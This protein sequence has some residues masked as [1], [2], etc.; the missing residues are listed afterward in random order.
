MRI[1]VVV[2]GGMGETLQATPLLRTLRAGFPQ[3]RISLLHPRLATAVAC[4]IPSADELVPERC[5]EGHAGPASLIPLWL[6][7]RRRRLDA[8]FIC[9]GQP[10]LRVAAYLAGVPERVGPSGGLTSVL[11]T[12]GTPA[13]EHENHAATWLRLASSLGLTVQ[14]HAPSFDPGPEAKR[15]ANKLLHGTGLTDGRLLIAIVPGTSLTER[16][17]SPVGAVGWDPQRFAFLAN[18]LAQR[19]GAGIVFLGGPGDRAEIEQVQ[20]D[21]GI[22]VADMSGELD[23][24][25]VAAIVSHCDLLVAADSP[26]LHIAAAV[27]TPAVGLFG[28][29]DGRKRGPYGRDHRII[30]ALPV[31]QAEERAES[32]M[33]RIR[34]DDVLAGIE[35][36]L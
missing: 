28:P 1:A 23:L 5:L 18:L 24:R 6:A 11:L 31:V 4:G 21:L 32:P 36:T 2:A 30:Q 17:G 7:L 22:S 16:N 26:L 35:A 29:T 14:V 34:V 9:G 12:S 8:T 33:S 20:M 27:G 25:I 13:A 3:A 10:A 15:E 19:H